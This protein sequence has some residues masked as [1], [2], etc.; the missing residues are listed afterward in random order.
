LTTVLVSAIGIVA[1]AGLTWIVTRPI[2]QLKEAAA[3]VGQGDFS[4]WLTPWAN[5]EIGQLTA[6]FNGMTAALA[7]AEQERA[8]RDQLRS[9]LLEKVIAAQEDE[10]RRIARELHDETG[11]ALTSLMVRLQMM[12]RF[13]R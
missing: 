3:A 13:M 12:N 7:Q 6:A 4:Q 11:Q 1:A 8:E 9:Q 2:L 10:R 5:D